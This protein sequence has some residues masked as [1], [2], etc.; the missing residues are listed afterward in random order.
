MRI[1]FA[2]C[3]TFFV[4]GLSWAG[5]TFTP[6]PGYSAPLYFSGTN[7]RAS[8]KC[9][10]TNPDL[11]VEAT[12]VLINGELLTS[13][14]YPIM[15]F[16]PHYMYINEVT[17]PIMFDSKY[18]SSGTT[19]TIKMRAKAGGTWYEDTYS[20]P[21]KN[22]T[23]A[24][25]RDEWENAVGGNGATT[26]HNKVTAIGHNCTLVDW[27]GWS[28]NTVQS[29]QDWGT[30]MY[31]NTHG[32]VDLF[33]ADNGD[34]IYPSSTYGNPNVLA[35]RQS[36]MGTSGPLPPFNTTG[37]PPVDL[38][39][40]DT[41][42]TGSNDHFL[43]WL[44]PYYNGYGGLYEDQAI[45]GWT[46]STYVTNAGLLATLLWNKLI[47]EETIGRSR[48]DMIDK[49]RNIYGVKVTPSGEMDR[50]IEDGD[51]V[52]YGDQY[53]RYAGVYTGTNSIHTAWWRR[54]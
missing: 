33:S 7:A 37:N 30:T 46:V 17:I 48:D 32:L 9:M 50:T 25:G 53:M 27:D 1:V 24:M 31:F 10:V 38:V 39:V 42:L 41:C 4:A 45:A 35:W 44:F 34:L 52:V 20:A 18:F 19:V 29:M 40:F 8:Y 36:V 15:G 12:Q 5:I 16:P 21:A 47:T 28:A 14:T 6:H 11:H 22:Y 13:D 49:A 43:T 2:I 26:V 54:L 3:L 51:F 23:R